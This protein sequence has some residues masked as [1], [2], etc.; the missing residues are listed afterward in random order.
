VT[1]VKALLGDKVDKKSGYSLV[2]DTEITKLGT[3]AEGANKYTHPNYT[4]QTSGL[5]KITVDSTGHVSAVTAVTAADLTALGM[6]DM[7]T[8]KTYVAEQIGDAINSSY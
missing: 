1:K 6:V 2:S 8:V 4:A 3:V 5:Y 7:D